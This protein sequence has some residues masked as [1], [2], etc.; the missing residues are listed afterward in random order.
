MLASDWVW[1]WHRLKEIVNRS[2][3]D[4]ALHLHLHFV[5]TT[6]P[7]DPDDMLME[8]N[9]HRMIPRLVHDYYFCFQIFIHL[10]VLTLNDVTFPNLQ[11]DVYRLVMIHHT[12]GMIAV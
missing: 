8:E 7:V 2:T 1:M 10:D 11:D 5:S 3:E 9:C 6:P 4:S 12:G